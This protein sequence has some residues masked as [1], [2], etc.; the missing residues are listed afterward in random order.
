MDIK[1]RKQG[2]VMIVNINGNLDGEAAP[3]FQEMIEHWTG[4]DEKKFVIDAENL[5]YISSSGLRCFIILSKTA[6][7]MGGNVVFCN[8]RGMVQEIFDISNF[9]AMFSIEDNLEDALKQL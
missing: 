5:D 3:D 1:T 2:D 4:K 8:V 9:P 7:A 6:K